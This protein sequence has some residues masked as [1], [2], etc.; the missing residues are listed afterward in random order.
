MEKVDEENMSKETRKNQAANSQDK[1][2]CGT[3]RV[4]GEAAERG[5]EYNGGI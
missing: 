2:L 5:K 3:R 1:Q 4:A